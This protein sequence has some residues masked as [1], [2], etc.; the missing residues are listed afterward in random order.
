[1]LDTEARLYHA[2]DQ[3]PTAGLAAGTS[4]YTTLG[5][6][7]STPTQGYERWSINYFVFNS[8]HYRGPIEVH[9]DKLRAGLGLA[10]TA[11][12]LLH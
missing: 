4:T 6:G 2:A 1:M 3:A 11:F 5:A 8:S 10:L 12:L 7:T 9:N